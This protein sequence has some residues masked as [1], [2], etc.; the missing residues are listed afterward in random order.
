MEEKD[1]WYNEN[2]PLCNLCTGDVK[3]K[4]Y[5]EDADVIVVDCETHNVPMFVIKRHSAEPTIEETAH[6]KDLIDTMF[7]DQPFRGPHT[8]MD[9]FHW[10]RE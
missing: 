5:H 4:L 9:H 6:I 7:S 2:C 3:T 8:I 10:H 1:T